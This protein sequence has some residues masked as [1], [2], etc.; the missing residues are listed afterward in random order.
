MRLRLLGSLLS[1]AAAFTFLIAPA[2][3]DDS[4]VCSGAD[5]DICSL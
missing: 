5:S 1:A 2:F 4:D 3:A